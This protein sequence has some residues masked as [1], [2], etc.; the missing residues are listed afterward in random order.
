VSHLHER[1]D[2]NCLN[3]GTEVAGRYCQN[4]GQENAEPKETFWQLIVH[5]FNDI[6]HFDGKF[7]KTLKLLILRPGFLTSEYVAGRR[8]SYLH[9][10]RMYLF[11]SFLVFLVLF[12]LPS[13]EST[14]VPSNSNDSSAQVTNGVRVIRET[15][16]ADSTR[17]PEDPGASRISISTDRGFVSTRDTSIEAYLERQRSLPE[18]QR[19]NSIRRYIIKKFILVNEYGRKHPD[20]FGDEIMSRFRR[21]IPQLFFISIPIFAFLLYL[22]YV[23]RRQAFYYVSHGIFSIHFYCAAYVFF[24][25]FSLIGWAADRINH[26]Q[27][28]AALVTLFYLY[29]AMRKFYK[30]RRAKTVFKY[31]VLTFVMF[32][33]LGILTALFLVNSLFK[34]PT[35]H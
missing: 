13:G 3:C 7:F 33:L 26:F 27:V 34:V 24:L 18:S 6:T 28:L 30:Q 11:I 22:L 8:A 12:S 1:V 35:A 2:K 25:V 10:I 31:L 4:C 19:D 15:E 29:K 20:T 14:F 9:P 21:S 16:R 17:L 32:F 23:R 5:F